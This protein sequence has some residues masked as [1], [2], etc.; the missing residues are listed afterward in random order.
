MIST[1]LPYLHFGMERQGFARARL[2]LPAY[3]DGRK[4]EKCC[5][6][7]TSPSLAM[8]G[9]PEKCHN[10]RAKQ[11]DAVSDWLNPFYLGPCQPPLT[12]RM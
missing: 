3:D 4:R 9:Q 11:K 2:T 12:L 8:A 6:C 5:I 10:V 7:I 1:R